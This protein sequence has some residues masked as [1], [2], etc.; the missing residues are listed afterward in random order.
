MQSRKSPSLCFALLTARQ[1]S[2]V[3]LDSTRVGRD[4]TGACSADALVSASITL[5]S[6]PARAIEMSHRTSIHPLV[7][8]SVYACRDESLAL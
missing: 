8:F 4:E 1:V 6:Q 7:G 3:R 2:E 5:L